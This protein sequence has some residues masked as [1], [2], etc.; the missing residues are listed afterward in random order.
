V[1]ATLS[2]NVLGVT[3]LPRSIVDLDVERWA[4]RID[5]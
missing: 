1:S 4:T 5:W 3:N 2:A